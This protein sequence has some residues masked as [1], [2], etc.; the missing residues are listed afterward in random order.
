MPVEKY[1]LRRK[2]GRVKSQA[3][4]IAILRGAK[5]IFLAAGF[6]GASMDDVAK[7]SGV[8][9]MT[10]YRHFGSKEDLFAGVI[11]DLGSRIVKQ[12]LERIFAK[13]PEQALRRYARKMM[14]IVFDPETIELHRIVIAESNR[15]P[16]LGRF[17]YESG[18]QVCIDVLAFYLKKNVANPK[19]KI[20]DPVRA[21]EEF[22][23]LLRGYAHLRV[24]LKI[25]KA[26]T[27]QDI[28]SRVEGAMRH[29]LSEIG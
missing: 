11:Q 19:F 8:S 12:D 16:K 15:F 17:F 5:A 10:V 21:S 28:Q 1:N 27:R 25:D 4:R 9:K 7:R 24:L 14:N 18:P 29:L 6:E 3:K 22:L 20:A 2:R 23:E 26:P 13:A